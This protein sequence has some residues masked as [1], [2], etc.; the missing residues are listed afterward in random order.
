MRSFVLLSSCLLLVAAAPGQILKNINTVPQPTSSVP[1]DSSPGPFVRAGGRVYFAATGGLGRE[2]YWA[3]TTGAP[4]R[5]LA[6]IEL[7]AAGSNPRQ[8]VQLANGLVFVHRDD[9]RA[10]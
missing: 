7:G 2:L 1:V 4:A 3:D 5:L 10:W 8:I 9:Q 6:D